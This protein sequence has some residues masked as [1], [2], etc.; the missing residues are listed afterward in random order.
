MHRVRG[1]GAEAARAFQESVDLAATTILEQYIADGDWTP[2]NWAI[3]S[4]N[5][6]HLE[7]ALV[8][9]LEKAGF[10][11]M[12]F[13][14]ERFYR[15]YMPAQWKGLHVIVVNGFY[16]SASD[17]FPRRE[18][19]P[20]LWRHEPLTVFGGGCGFWKA[21]YLVE[22]NEFMVP[23]NQGRHSAVLCNAPK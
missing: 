22:R 15:Q 8:S 17:L 20:D 1:C 3:S 13:K 9:A 18:I 6:D 4:E 10:G 2:S 14:P 23:T 5:L 19:S 21:V 12:S 16:A 11:T 7:V